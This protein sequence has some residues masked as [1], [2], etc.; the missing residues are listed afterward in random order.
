MTTIPTSATPRL[1]PEELLAL[2]GDHEHA[3]LERYRDLAF[4]FLAFNSAT[5]RL[6]ATLGIE[7]ERRL[8]G[9]ARAA[10]RLG[11]DL[12]LNLGLDKSRANAAPCLAAPA[13]T[14]PDLIDSLAMARD[15]LSQAI[16]DAAASQRLYVRLGELGAGC[17]LGH[18]FVAIA[19]HKQAELAI[20][21][22]HCLERSPW[23]LARRRA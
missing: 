18:D 16:T 5:S 23:L 10:R 1:L 12:S 6:M 9:L 20:L 8:S 2:A 22:E 17:S 11:P 15:A 19:H 13:A 14:A 3:E 21:R 4:R 7:C